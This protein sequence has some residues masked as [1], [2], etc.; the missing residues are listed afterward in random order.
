MLELTYNGALGGAILSNE[1]SI[2]HYTSVLTRVY[3][4]TSFVTGVFG[5][6]TELPFACDF[7]E[8]SLFLMLFHCMGRV[9]NI[10]NELNATPTSKACTKALLYTVR[11]CGSVLGGTKCLRSVAPT[12]ATVPISTPGI[13]ASPCASLFVKILF[14]TLVAIAPP[15]LE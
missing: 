15:R 11:T 7:E 10:A 2:L 1:R 4:P 6:I 12:F 8:F 14:A 3:S 5:I 13:R 9:P